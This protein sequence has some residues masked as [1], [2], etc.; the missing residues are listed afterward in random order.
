M[1]QCPWEEDSYSA[2]Q[3]IPHLLWNFKVVYHVQKSLPL[4][5]T[6]TLLN[7]VYSHTPLD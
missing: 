1:E 3:Y 4:D 5:F 6:M 7:W 2:K